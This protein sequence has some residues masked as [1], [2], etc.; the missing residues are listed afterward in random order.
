M[1][2]ESLKYIWQATEAPSAGE[3]DRQALLAL[4]QKRSR[5]PVARMRRNLSIELVLLLMAYI[6]AILFYLWQPGHLPVI[7]A[8]LFL[9]GLLF[10]VYYY[11]KQRLLKNMLC[12][13]CEVRSNLDRQVRTLKKYISFYLWSGTL[14]IPIIGLICYG[15]FY[16]QYQPAPDTALFRQL[17]PGS[18]WINPTL[19]AV[20]LVPFTIG[21]YYFN[22]WYLNKLYGQHI[23][24][25]QELLR[26]LDEDEVI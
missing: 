22:A 1:E 6:P 14:M 17:H 23:K 15:I 18:W 12:M 21:M 7:S 10:V 19:W 20:I 26:E 9:L 2:L 24:K 16:W 13:T 8:L 3:T 5:G 25:L 4:L 11:R